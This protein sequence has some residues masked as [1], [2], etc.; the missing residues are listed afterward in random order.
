MS[1]GSHIPTG[2]LTPEATPRDQDFRLV[3]CPSAGEFT[4]AVRGFDDPFMNWALGIAVERAAEATTSDASLN[5]H[6]SSSNTHANPD[7]DVFA[8]VFQGTQLILALA[9][10]TKRAAYFLCHPTTSPPPLI[11]PACALLATSPSLDLTLVRSLGGP[12]A[13]LAALLAASPSVHAG[14]PTPS[15]TAPA[16]A[17][18]LALPRQPSG[19]G[20][21]HRGWRYKD[22][23]E[24]AQC[25]VAG[26]LLL[27]R[28]T[29]R[30]VAIRNVFVAPEHRRRGL[31]ETMVGA[32]TRACLGAR[33]WKRT[34]GRACG[35]MAAE[36]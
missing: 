35:S 6:P 30:T 27:G 14:S 2:S 5:E 8:A 15:H 16:C 4:D 25:D 36:K 23:G 1:P 26:Y 22:E 13:A 9:H 34:A 33:R 32:V 12:R 10:T 3:L 11:A 18:T 7:R 24:N 17:A 19:R 31:A 21:V 28:N 20:T 29:P